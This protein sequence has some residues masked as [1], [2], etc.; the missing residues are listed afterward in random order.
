MK[1]NCSLLAKK[2][3]FF[4][5]RDKEHLRSKQKKLSN[6]PPSAWQNLHSDQFTWISLAWGTWKPTEPYVSPELQLC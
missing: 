2:G 3:K 5:E 4:T 1:Y 6:S